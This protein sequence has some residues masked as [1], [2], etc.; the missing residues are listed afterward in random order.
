MQRI[1]TRHFHKIRSISR[2]YYS[3]TKRRRNQIPKQLR[4]TLNHALFTNHRC[5]LQNAYQIWKTL[6]P[7][8]NK[9]GLFISTMKKLF[10]CVS[11]AI[12]RTPRPAFPPCSATKAYWNNLVAGGTG[13]G[14]PLSKG[15]WTTTWGLIRKGGAFKTIPRV[16]RSCLMIKEDSASFPA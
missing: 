9:D 7:L 16:P 10:P 5:P 1:V 3:V 2:W 6:F 11:Q 12:S 4:Y 15:F 13:G 14:L 8:L